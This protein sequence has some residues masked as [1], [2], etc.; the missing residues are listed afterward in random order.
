VLERSPLRGGIDLLVGGVNIQFDWL[1]SGDLST[2]G[3]LLSS[4]RRSDFPPLLTKG[5]QI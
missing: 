1:D 3:S 4:C 2:K 5:S